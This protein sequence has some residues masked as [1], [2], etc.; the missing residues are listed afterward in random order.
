MD[1]ILNQSRIES[2]FAEMQGTATPPAASVKPKSKAK[3]D[4][5][6]FRQAGQIT[7]EQMKAISSVN[8]YFAINVKHTVGAL[9]RT[10]FN[11]KLVSGEQL[12]YAEFLDRVLEPTYL[13]SVRLEPLGATGLLE[14]DV[15]LALPIIDLLLGG[16]G[17]PAP[18]RNLTDM[19]EEILKS[20]VQLIVHEL[21]TAW[22]AIGLRFEFDQRETVGSA[23]RTMSVTEKTL[24]LSFEVT[25]Q[26]VSG[27]LNFCL[28]A[29]LNSILKKYAS[30][31]DRRRR[32]SPE[33]QTR[34][35]ELVG[36]TTVGMTLRF[37]PMRLHAKE[38]AA[39]A[40]GNVL[41]L[42]MS[43]H[44]PAE[45]C[46]GGVPMARAHPVRSAEHRGAQIIEMIPNHNMSAA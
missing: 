16:F 46:V 19:E 5:Y 38:L 18:Y 25:M 24:A 15:A 31:Q 42:P 1:K 45:L 6:K 26:D 10:K 23:A 14:F 3:S 39:L 9:L 35:R 7:D 8:D 20:V 11:V 27:A 43:R 2:L 22:A 12:P 30:E 37:T 40:P 32:P 41:R 28:P 13:C 36:T 21:N 29:T 33:N 17:G 44:E 34:L 4:V